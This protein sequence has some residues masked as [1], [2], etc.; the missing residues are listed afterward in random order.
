MASSFFNTWSWK[1][2]CIISA[3]LEVWWHWFR[4][5][6]P[7]WK[8]WNCCHKYCWVH[9]RVEEIEARFYSFLASLWLPI[10]LFRK[11]YHS[12]KLGPYRNFK[13]SCWFYRF[14]DL[15]WNNILAIYCK[16]WWKWMYLMVVCS[17]C[18]CKSCFSLC[19][20]ACK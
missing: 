2:T 17:M 20:C 14:N 1:K 13:K 4:Y 5:W 9:K 11:S 18:F 6:R 10:S 16:L 19:F 7:Y 15:L 8:W 12:F 3:Y